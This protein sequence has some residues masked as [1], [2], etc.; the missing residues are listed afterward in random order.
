MT[1]VRQK[2]TLRIGCCFRIFLGAGQL[3]FN[4]FSF[5][6][7]AINFKDGYRLALVVVANGLPGLHHDRATVA[8]GMDQFTFPTTRSE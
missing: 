3:G 1:H 2:M 7:V 8:S 4:E 5:G 6:D